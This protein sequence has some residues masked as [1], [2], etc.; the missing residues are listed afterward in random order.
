MFENYFREKDAYTKFC[1]STCTSDKYLHSIFSCAKNIMIESMIFMF[2]TDF[3]KKI[4]FTKNK[5]WYLLKP[6]ILDTPVL[7]K[8]W[9]FNI[10]T[11]FF[12]M[13]TFNSVYVRLL[14][15]KVNARSS[16]YTI[17]AGSTFVL[18]HA[19]S[20]LHHTASSLF[21]IF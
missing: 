9:Q 1:G 13:L 18:I 12:D 11:G 10:F 14:K 17:H 21:H 6:I 15:Q 5:I 2:Y 8:G 7:V 3:T 16:I 4:F 19:L 20:D